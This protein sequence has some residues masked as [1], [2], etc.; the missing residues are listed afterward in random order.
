MSGSS[1]CSSAR[2]ELAYSMARSGLVHRCG[3]GCPSDSGN[4]K[5][6]THSSRVTVLSASDRMT[7]PGFALARAISSDGCSR[8][9]PL[10]IIRSA[11][12]ISLATEGAGSKVCEFTP[13]GTMPSSRIRV[14]PTFS[15]RLVIGETVVTTFSIPSSSLGSLPAPPSSDEQAMRATSARMK[16]RANAALGRNRLA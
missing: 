5:S 1:A 2:I 7:A 14:P 3:F 8:K 6:N 10:R 12:A 4:E 16:A 9:S 11:S 15:T 13:S